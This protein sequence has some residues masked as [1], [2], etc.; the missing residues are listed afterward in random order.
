MNTYCTNEGP[1]RGSF[2]DRDAQDW[3]FRVLEW[4]GADGPVGQARPTN[5]AHDGAA[6]WELMIGGSALPGRFVVRDPRFTPA[7]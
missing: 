4:P 5:S 7:C 6:L 2:W 1:E 3:A